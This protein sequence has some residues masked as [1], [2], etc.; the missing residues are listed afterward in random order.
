VSANR[1]ADSC[2]VDRRDVAVRTVR[3]HQRRNT[4]DLHER[5]VHRIERL[6][7][8]QAEEVDAAE[9]AHG[10]THATQRTAMRGNGIHCGRMLSSN[11]NHS[12]HLAVSPIDMYAFLGGGRRFLASG[13]IL[14]VFFVAAGCGGGGSSSASPSPPPAAQEM[15]KLAQ[16]GEKIF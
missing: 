7:G 10:G 3:M 11:K 15:S 1:F 5:R 9:R 6:L 4:V 16:L 13:A 2:R 14:A 12:Q 8:A